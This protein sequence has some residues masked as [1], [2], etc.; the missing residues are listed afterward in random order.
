MWNGDKFFLKK[1][2]RGGEE[3]AVSSQCVVAALRWNFAK[4]KTP[5]LEKMKMSIMRESKFRAK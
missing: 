2:C 4:R 1:S 3:M 5:R